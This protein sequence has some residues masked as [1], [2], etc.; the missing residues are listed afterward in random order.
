MGL[1][2]RLRTRRRAS[3]VRPVAVIPE[4]HRPAEGSSSAHGLRTCDVC[5]E[6]WISYFGELMDSG[7]LDRMA[8]RADCRVYA[9]WEQTLGLTCAGCGRSRCRQHLGQ[10]LRTGGV[11]QPSDYRCAH[12]ASPMDVA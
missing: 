11:P 3:S 6:R 9:S 8:A 10:T 4:E 7:R 2:D 12:C 5:G 1:L